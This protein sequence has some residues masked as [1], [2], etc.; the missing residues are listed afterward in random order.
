MRDLPKSNVGPADFIAAKECIARAEE[1]R[2]PHLAGRTLDAWRIVNG[3]GDRAPPSLTIDRY[4]TW[5]VLAAREAVHAETIEL[6]SR[7]A[8]DVIE[9]DGLVMKVLRKPA[10]ASTSRV[11]AGALPKDP[12]PIHEEDAV[13]LC[14]LNDG[15]STGLFLD[16]R[17]VRLA[18]RNFARDREVLNLFAHTCA[19]S[20]HAALAGARR[21]TSVDVS[22]KF[23]RRGRE[24]MIASG[25]DPDRHRWFP[26]DVRAHLERAARR[27]DSYGLVIVDPPVFGRAGKQ[28]HR[29]E[30]DL[31]ELVAKSAALV[32]PNGT[33]VL[34]VHALEIDSERIRA[35]ISTPAGR[36]VT[37]LDE[38]GLPA[39]DHPSREHAGERGDRGHYLKALVL[40][41][42]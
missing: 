15:T 11:F 17:E 1:R 12:L 31:E 35:A 3:A 8:L 34:A 41:V 16:L 18:I 24:N 40:K 36:V 7:A 32:A 14:D 33:L 5:L 26:D 27:G 29:L 37:V 23:L 21:V 20:V 13:L 22:K 9:A 39:W 10:S 30:E 25:L 42:A 2:R 19:F 28:V 38:L 6:W 4:A